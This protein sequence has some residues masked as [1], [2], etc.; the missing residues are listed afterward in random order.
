MQN[1]PQWKTQNPCDS[2]SLRCCIQGEHV[3]RTAQQQTSELAVL[4]EQCSNHAK[5]RA[6]LKTILDAKIRALVDDIGQ[7]V[8]ETSQEV[9]CRLTTKAEAGLCSQHGLPMRS[10]TAN[11]CTQRVVMNKENAAGNVEVIWAYSAQKHVHIHA[12]VVMSQICPL[13]AHKTTPEAKC[14]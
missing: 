10:F 6:A 14:S 3:D 7:T 1:C 2:L 5:E 12:V 8:A 9:G 4:R 11:G 13:A